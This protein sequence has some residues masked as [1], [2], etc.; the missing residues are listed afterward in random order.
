MTDTLAWVYRGPLATGRDFVVMDEDDLEQAVRDD[1]AQRVVGAGEGLHPSTVFRNIEPGPH[2][3]AEAYAARKGKGGG[4][5]T[6]ELT[7]APPAPPAPPELASEDDTEVETETETD[8][9]DQKPV[10]KRRNKGGETP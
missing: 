3:A 5:A 6:R 4:Y 8:T 9:E 2:E 7:P 10:R 1:W